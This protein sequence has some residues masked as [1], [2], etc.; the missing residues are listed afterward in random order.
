MSRSSAREAAD[1]PDAARGQTEPLA[2]L[3]ALFAV[4]AAVTLYVGVLGDVT[5]GSDRDLASPTL[6][7][8]HDAVTTAGVAV[9]DRLSAAPAAGPDG[10]RVAAT[11]TVADREWRVGPTPPP[12]ATD[13]AVRSVGVR[14]VPGRVRAG[15]LRVVVWS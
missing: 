3:A 11:L 10:Y 2:A 5:P 12:R 8:V 13:V 14:I 15:R 4:C 6:D 9:P 7:R 1:R